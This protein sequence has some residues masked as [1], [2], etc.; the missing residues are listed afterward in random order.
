MAV[1]TPELSTDATAEAVVVQ[2]KPPVVASCKVVAD[3]T[4]TFSVPVISAGSG[5]TIKLIV[6]VQPKGEV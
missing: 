3:P 6:F 5:F 2:D 1:T 4:Q